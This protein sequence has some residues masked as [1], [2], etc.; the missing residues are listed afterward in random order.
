MEANILPI[1]KRKE[2][3]NAG[4]IIKERAPDE[5]PNDSEDKEEYSLTDCAHDILDAIRS[6]SAE[7]LA[8]ALKELFQKL[9]KEPHEEGPH[10]EKHTY[11]AQ[12][13]KAGQDNG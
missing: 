4:L 10:V 12:N 8:T 9:D 6:D 7:S 2:Q 11:Q 1:L 3:G 13:I 5:K